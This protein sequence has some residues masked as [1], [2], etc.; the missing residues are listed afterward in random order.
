MSRRLS[1]WGW[2]WEDRFPDLDTRK[3]FAQQVRLLGGLEDPLEIREPV[4]LEE[5]TLPAPRV[6]V[7]DKWLGPIATTRPFD[8]ASRCYGRA[9][10]DIVR[11]FSG[12]FG[13]APDVVLRPEDE[14]QVRMA[15]EWAV[16]RDVALVPYGGGTSVVGGVEMEARDYYAGVACLDLRGLDRVV[17]VDDVSLAARIQAGATGPRLEDQ[18]R[19]H[20]LTL[21]F[22]PQS[23]E[24]S[25]LG[26]WIAT[27]AGGHFATL[28]THIDDLVESAR[29]LTPRGVFE[30]R[31]L[32][33]SGAGPSPDRL[34]LG[35]EGTLGVITEAWMR[36]RPRPLWR[37][38]ASVRF[39]SWGDI[40]TATRVIAQSGLYPSNCRVLDKREALMNRVATDGRHVLLLGFESADH[41]VDVPMERALE[42][43]R[44]HRGECPDGPSYVKR[45]PEKKRTPDPAPE[46][47]AVRWRQAF[48]DAPYLINSMVSLGVIA[49]TFETATTWDRFEALH[50]NVIGDVRAA[51]KRACGGG[52]I[53]CRFTHVYPD[54]CAPYFTFVAPAKRG[55]ELS[56]WA[57]IKAAASDAII[58]HAGTITHHHAVGRM[59]R[60]WYD[61]QRPEPFG[62]VL[63]A[64]KRTLDPNGVL[65]PGVL[66]PTPRAPR[67]EG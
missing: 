67:D 30:S 43:V 6:E 35:S 39:A 48:L 49:D 8:R 14:T 18:L 38:S 12:D 5:A 44:D 54:G 29:M 1:H 3:M 50:R 21:R 23:F 46:S 24:L 11:G 57:E 10:R 51:M 16:E 13:A 60:P 27:R 15:L 58:A 20:D 52:I 45:N 65:N 25:T 42:I 64:V 53:T 62:D 41:P 7:S 36:V 17:E 26:G 55:Y 28:M 59:H 66:R 19:E 63:D 9:Y 37:A 33:G 56:Q 22:Y 31:R 2:G 61:Q 34:V 40:V 4:P 47:D 32:P